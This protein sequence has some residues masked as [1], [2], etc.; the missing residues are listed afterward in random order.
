MHGFGGRARAAGPR[1]KKDKGKRRKAG[2]SGVVAAELLSRGMSSAAADQGA[3]HERLWL[4]ARCFV[5]V[6]RKIR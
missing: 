5:F 3:Q 1:R 2:G 4:G 6:D